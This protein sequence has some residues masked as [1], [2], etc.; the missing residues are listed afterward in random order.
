M[1]I[2]LNSGSDQSSRYH[3]D[4]LKARR[5]IKISHHKHTARHLPIRYTSYAVLFF[6]LAFSVLTIFFVKQQIVVAGPPQTLNGDIQLSGVVPGPPPSNPPFVSGPTDGQRFSTNQIDVTGGCESGLIIE[7]YRNDTFAGSQI[8]DGSNQ[9]TITITL[10]AGE[11]ILR[12]RTKDGIG[13][14]GPDAPLLTVYYDA[15]TVEDLVVDDEIQPRLTVEE[16]EERLETILNDPLLVITDPLHDGFYSK[17]KAAISYELRGGAAP[18]AVAINWGDGSKDSLES[19]AEAAKYSTTHVYAEG[20][21]YKVTI[22]I[23]DHSG[24]QATIQTIVVISGE[25][26]KIEQLISAT[27][28]VNPSLPSCPLNSQ[29]L[30]YI[31][32]AWPALIGATFIASSFWLGEQVVYSRTASGKLKKLPK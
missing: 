11:N 24:N 19:K 12:T 28:D 30:H 32:Q 3:S 8:C 9:F 14:Y 16:A 29:I 27:C 22:T 21:Q 15:P 1:A 2:D 17:Q 4:I 25:K 10:V 26:Q 13:Q 31:D 20:G 18:Y 5:P 23:T 6:I 7:V